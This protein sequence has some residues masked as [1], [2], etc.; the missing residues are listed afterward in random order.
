MMSK[1]LKKELAN[2][3]IQ[4][5]SYNMTEHENYIRENAFLEAEKFFNFGIEKYKFDPDVYENINWSLTFYWE[6][7]ENNLLVTIEY[8]G[9]MSYDCLID[10]EQLKGYTYVHSVI[11]DMIDKIFNH[12]ETQIEML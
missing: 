12:K 11:F 3:K 1:F 6:W 5:P 10:N 4:L 8:D 2:L 9:R 7:G